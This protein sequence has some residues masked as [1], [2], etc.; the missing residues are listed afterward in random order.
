MSRRGTKG[1]NIDAESRVQDGLTE[2][3]STNFLTLYK[4]RS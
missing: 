3:Q 2:L 1:E 4:R